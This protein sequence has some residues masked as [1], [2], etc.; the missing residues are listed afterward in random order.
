MEE[1]KTLRELLLQWRPVPYETLPDI[2]LYKDQVL[3][4]MQRQQAPGSLQE[5]L[6]GAMVNNY[7][8]NG[9]LP[10]P[11]G[12]R[13]RRQHLAMLTAVCQLKQVLSVAEAGQLLAAQ[14]DARDPAALYGQYLG[15]LDKALCQTAQALP[16]ADPG[17]KEEA[18]RC[19]LELAVH[20]YA[21]QLAAR[22]LLALMEQLPQE[23]QKP[24]ENRQKN[25]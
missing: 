4:Y 13:Y 25:G 7:I 2:D 23:A 21:C 14:P 6:T 22:K 10:R 20:S 11:E 12:K 16:Q 24:A 8:K 5:E 15:Q 3:A 9:V 19:A 17:T 18:A 1:P